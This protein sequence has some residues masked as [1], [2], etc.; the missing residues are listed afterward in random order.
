MAVA[1]VLGRQERCL[2]VPMALRMDLHEE[3]KTSHPILS[4]C[5]SVVLCLEKHKPL[6]SCDHERTG[7]FFVYRFFFFELVEWHNVSGVVIDAIMNQTDWI[8]S[9]TRRD[10]IFLPWPA[11]QFICLPHDGQHGNSLGAHA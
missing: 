3:I 8:E 11:Q 7:L 1:V 2:S 5:I 9:H 4:M 10:L 6:V